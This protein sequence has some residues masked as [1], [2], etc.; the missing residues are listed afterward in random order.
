MTDCE[1]IRNVLL[2]LYSHVNTSVK[3][4]LEKHPND[5]LNYLDRFIKHQ[6]T[7]L[8]VNY[9][10]TNVYIQFKLKDRL[11]HGTGFT[12]FIKFTYLYYEESIEL[13]EVTN[14]NKE[15]PV[16][17]IKPNLFITPLN[18]FCI[19][20][21]FWKK[22]F[23]KK[24]NINMHHYLEKEDVIMIGSCFYDP[25]EKLSINEFLKQ[26]GRVTTPRHYTPRNGFEP[27]T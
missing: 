11:V 24:D 20:F 18:I 25:I 5:F 13:G 12:T 6:M 17:Y 14:L 26:Y 15:Y 16:F 8:Q 7:D 4:L 9:F 19:L 27:L 23:D 2:I 1:K 22:L 21:T 10:G 3:Y